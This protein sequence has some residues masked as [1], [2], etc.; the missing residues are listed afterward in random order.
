MPEIDSQAYNDQIA[1]K[2]VFHSRA[3]TNYLKYYYDQA[4]DGTLIEHLE[5][6]LKKQGVINNNNSDSELLDV[7]IE[8]GY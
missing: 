5:Q 8:G 6:D 2:D 3:K 7:F 4:R 1:R